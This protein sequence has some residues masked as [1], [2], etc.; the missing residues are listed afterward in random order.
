MGRIYM[1]LPFPLRFWPGLLLVALL[2]GCSSIQKRIA[3][4]PDAFAPLSPE[5]KQTI[6]DGHVSLGFTPVMVYMALGK[7]SKINTSADGMETTWTYIHYNTSEGTISLSSPAVVGLMPS[8]RFQGV[9]RRHMAPPAIDVVN[10]SQPYRGVAGETDLYNG[11]VRAPDGRIREATASDMI[12][13]DVG[14]DLQIRFR[15][16]FVVGFELARAF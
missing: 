9:P 7:P 16:G 1:N 14:Q 8:R 3:E 6:R 2:A 4:N 12:A 10:D 13:G 15:D 5:A 11:R